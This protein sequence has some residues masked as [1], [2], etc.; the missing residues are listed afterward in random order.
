VAQTYSIGGEHA[1]PGVAA[2]AIVE[3]LDV[4]EDRVGQ[5][6]AT[7][8]PEAISAGTARLAG[9]DPARLFGEVNHPLSS[10]PAYQEMANAVNPR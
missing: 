6:Q 7:E 2:L 4:F 1:E 5:F 9:T 8:R 3:D 10:T